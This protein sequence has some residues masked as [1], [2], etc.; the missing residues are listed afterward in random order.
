VRRLCTSLDL[1]ISLVVAAL[2]AATAFIANGGLQL[3]SSTL[4]EVSVVLVA[5]VV[6]AVAMLAVGFAARLHGGLALASLVVLTVLTG[7]S[8]LWS[9]YPSESWVETNRTLSY[10][11]AFGA[12]IAAV[13]LARDR[14]PA[15][16]AGVLLGLTV[17][18]LWGLATKVAPGWLAEH[19]TYGRLREPYGYWNAV[20]VTAAMGMPLCLWLGTRQS[21]RMFVNALAWPLLGLLTVT[22][23]LSFSRGSIVAAL[24]GVAIWLAFVPLRLR[25]LAALLPST[26][27]AAGVTAWAFAESA[28]TDDRIALAAREDAGVKFGLILLVMVVLLFCVGIAIQLRAERRPLAEPTRRRIGIAAIAVVASMPFILLGA[29]AFSERGIGGTVSD[30]WHDLTSSDAATPQNE[31]G[32]LTETSSVRSIYWSRAIDVWEKHPAAGAGAGSFAEAQLRFRNEPAQGKHA[33][34]YV[35]QTLAD[36]GILGLAVSLIALVI[37]LLAVRAT[38]ALRRGNVFGVDWSVERVGLATLAIVTVVFGVHSALDWTWFVPA[39]AMTALFSAGWVAG[40][41]PLG[42][43]GVRAEAGGAAAAVPPLEA[44]RPSRPRGPELKRRAPAAVALIAVAAVTALAIAQPWRAEQKGEDALRL[45]VAGDVTAAREAAEKAKDLN[46]LSVQPYFELATVE[47]A[48]GDTDGATSL[49]ERAVRLQPASPEAW[50][51]LGDHYLVSLGEPHRALPVLRAALFLDPVSPAG[52]A[53]F[54][55]ALRAS[56]LAQAEAAEA[57]K[58]RRKSR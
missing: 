33:H 23:L 8:I 55:A 37:W 17:V 5:A 50:R 2:V 40:R 30:R 53:S 39:V 21:G 38:L 57:A 58:K 3:G 26:L 24:A 29:L 34:G 9:L 12:G 16:L 22:L 6:A 7:L 4:V 54:V 52:R 13:R 18:C 47:E 25:S 10:L 42:A 1:A 48:A 15:I 14:W 36:L 19:E 44:V 43:S 45:A 28:L 11:A 41:G 32:R 20:G 27:V 56:Q 35:L 51:R 46:P 49:L 31:P